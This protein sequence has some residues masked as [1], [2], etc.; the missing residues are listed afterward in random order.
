MCSMR[1]I[2][3][4]KSKTLDTYFTILRIVVIWAS[5]FLF[6]ILNSLLIAKLSQS[7]YFKRTI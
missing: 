2:G 7:T 5:F 1:N 3:Q 4:T 6:Y